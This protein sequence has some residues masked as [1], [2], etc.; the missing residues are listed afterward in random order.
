MCHTYGPSIFVSN[1]SSPFIPPYNFSRSLIWCSSIIHKIKDPDRRKTDRGTHHKKAGGGLDWCTGSSKDEEKTVE[2]IQ[3]RVRETE[4]QS[5]EGSTIVK[6]RIECIQGGSIWGK[7]IACSQ[8]HRVQIS[9]SSL[10]LCPS[11][12]SLLFGTR[13]RVYVCVMWFFVFCLLFFCFFTYLISFLWSL[14]LG[15]YTLLYTKCLLSLVFFIFLFTVRCPSVL[16]I[17][18]LPEREHKQKQTAT[19]VCQE[20]REFLLF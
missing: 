17:S 6:G 2:E 14:F 3:M 11:I 12:P 1:F 5:R 8:T 13:T 4:M 10:S 9:A 16:Y 20:T 7:E 18:I 19:E 15:C